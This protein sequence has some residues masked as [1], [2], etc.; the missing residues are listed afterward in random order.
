M[1]G[2][3]GYVEKLQKLCQ[4]RGIDQSSLAAR[5]GLSRSSMSR[6]LSGAQEPKLR[7][8]HELARAL[9]VTL[10]FLVDDEQGLGPG[11]QF[12]MVNSDE[13]TILKLV[14]R[15]GY[16]TSIDR[17][18]GVAPGAGE[19]ERGGRPVENGGTGSQGQPRS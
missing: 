15:L 6:I 8:A 17:L 10:D 12:V 4:L 2:S 7:L 18:L 14:R 9:G 19:E 16:E 1:V 11:D 5:L 13:Q 3:M